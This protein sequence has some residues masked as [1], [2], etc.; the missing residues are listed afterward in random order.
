ME[1]EEILEEIE[2]FD[3]KFKREAVEAAI[4]RKDEIVPELL[5]ILE[6][7]ADPA[8]AAELDSEDDYMAHLYA[9]YLL[10]QFRETR[11]YPLMLRIAL[12]SS[13]LLDSLFGD[14]LTS[15]F[16]SV[17]AS[18]CGGD[19]AG[20][21]ALIENPAVDQWV[22]GSALGALATLVAVGIKTR[23]EIMSYLATLF[24]GGLSDTNDVV[25]SDLVLYSTELCA[26]EL[27]PEIEKAYED[28]LADPSMIGLD[29]VRSD[30]AKGQAWAMEKLASSPHRKLIDD[31]VKEMEWWASFKEEEPKSALRPDPFLADPVL[32]TLNPWQSDSYSGY[33]RSAPKVG[34]N[35]PCPCASGKKYQ[36]CCGK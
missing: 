2:W 15:S 25:W 4:A 8:I 16:D 29:E 34:R 28:G 5:T 9:M 19:V 32:E 27:L 12:L 26:V 14:S 33:K 31:T 24:H 1:I 35:D 18:V 7:I 10:A 23:E 22:R 3:G 11:A 21:Q 30:L 20:L 36:K 13:D 17:F 6:E